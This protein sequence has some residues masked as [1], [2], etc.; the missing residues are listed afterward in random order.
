MRS[1][2]GNRSAIYSE[3]RIFYRDKLSAAGFSAGTVGSLQDIHHLPFTEKD[4]LRRSQAEHPPFGNHLACRPPDLARVYSTSG[5]T[6]PPC[7]IGFTRNGLDM[8]A[9]NVA[10]GYTAGDFQG[11]QGIVVS[12]KAGPFVA[13]AAYYGFDKIGCTTIPVSTGNSERL[14][15][16]RCRPWAQ[17]GSVVPRL[18]AF[19]CATGVWIGASIPPAWA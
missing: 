3:G 18:M 11:G 14:V 10:R 5:T 15:R 7:Y 19:I 6:G 9:T 8:V 12:V 1:T 4:V 16:A 2:I 17:Q 13:G